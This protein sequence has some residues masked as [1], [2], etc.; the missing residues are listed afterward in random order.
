MS[1]MKME[2]ESKGGRERKGEP[3]KK[4]KAERKN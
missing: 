3:K 4:I 1:K 2:Q